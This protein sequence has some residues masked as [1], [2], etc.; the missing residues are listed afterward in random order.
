MHIQP[1]QTLAHTHSLQQHHGYKPVKPFTQY[2]GPINPP[3]EDDSPVEFFTKV[4]GEATFDYIAQQNNLYACQKDQGQYEWEDTCAP[5]MQML[6]GMLYAMGIHHLPD[7]HDYWST[8]PLLS[9]PGITRGM[10]RTRFK[11]LMRNLHLNDNSQLPQCGD[12][13]YDKLYKIRPLLNTI[14]DNT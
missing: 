1:P 13:Q 8:D 7:I 9:V 3:A 6:I 11:M 12:S 5:E 4:F 14:M 10:P 2:V